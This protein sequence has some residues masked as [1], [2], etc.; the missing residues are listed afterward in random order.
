MVPTIALV[1]YQPHGVRCGMAVRWC[2]IA[3]P[4]QGD[5]SCHQMAII[6]A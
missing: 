5:A 4:Q 6:M 2:G 1:C 3:N